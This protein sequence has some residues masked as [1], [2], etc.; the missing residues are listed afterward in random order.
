MSIDEHP[1]LAA[2]SKQKDQQAIIDLLDRLVPEDGRSIPLL[3]D[4]SKGPQDVKLP[5]Y[6][7]ARSQVRVLRL[8]R[9]HL[10]PLENKGLGDGLQ[11]LINSVMDDDTLVDVLDDAF[12]IAY[13][14]FIHR[15]VGDRRDEDGQPV[16]VTDLASIEDVVFSLVPI[17]ARP[18]RKAIE[19]GGPLFSN[20]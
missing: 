13:P 20:G 16:R 2:D 14:G 9:P 5:G 7:S 8:L 11:G 4:P 15:A 19:A 17:V 10:A 3:V 6:V 18:I 1:A 12:D